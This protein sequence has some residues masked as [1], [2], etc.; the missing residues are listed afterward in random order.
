MGGAAARVGAQAVLALE[1]EMARAMLTPTAQRDPQAIYNRVDRIGLVREA[2]TLGWDTYF[3]T[4]GRPDLRDITVHSPAYLRAMDEL[5]TRFRAPAWRAYL[6][7]HV[8]ATY[9]PFLPKRFVDEHHA[10]RRLVSGVA[11]QRPRWKRCVSFAD[12]QLGELLAQPFVARAFPGESKVAAAAMVKQVQAAFGAALPGVTWLDDETRARARAKLDK[13][14]DLI[15][16]PE[17][18]R[19]YDFAL[20]RKSPSQNAVAAARHEVAYQ[21]AKIGKPVDRTEF[22]LT[23]ANR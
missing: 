14:E 15:G 6:T 1:T 16:Y 11:E 20:D 8:L 19:T 21:L 23:L 10:L 3:A 5:L 4:V 2:P 17:R 13:M 12:A 9:A 22:W 7:Y 18:W